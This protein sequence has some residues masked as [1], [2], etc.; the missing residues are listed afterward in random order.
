[1]YNHVWVR[2]ICVS[3]FQ[4]AMCAHFSYQLC[5][6]IFPVSCTGVLASKISECFLNRNRGVLYYCVQLGSIFC[7]ALSM[8]G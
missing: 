3:F 1:M 7:E 5:V 8:Y 2:I 6:C 4:S